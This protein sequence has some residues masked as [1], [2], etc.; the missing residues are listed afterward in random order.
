MVRLAVHP[1]NCN[2]KNEKNDTRCAAFALFEDTAL[3]TIV[4]QPSTMKQRSARSDSS[5]RSPMP[6]SRQRRRRRKR[7]AAQASCDPFV[8]LAAILV[9]SVL[10]F[11]G[12]VSFFLPSTSSS[13][14]PAKQPNTDTARD[15]NMGKITAAAAAGGSLRG[16]E[17]QNEAP[18][19]APVPAKRPPVKTFEG[20][21]TNPFEGWQPDPPPTTVS[22]A[23]RW[24]AC[25]DPKFGSG[26]D[27]TEFCREQPS[28]LEPI[29]D[30]S[31]YPGDGS[32]IP[33]VEIVRRMFLKGVDASGNAFP[34]PLDDE[35]C[36]PM[37]PR[38]QRKDI[39][40]E[41]VDAVN[42]S[43]AS[44]GAVVRPTRILCM[45]Y[46][47]A[48]AHP[49][50]IRAM[51]ETWMGRCDGFLA[52]S[53]ESDPR[54]P[55]I[56]LPHEGEEAY[57][58]M[59]QKVRSIWKFVGEHYVDRFDY[60]FLGGDDLFVVPENLRAYLSTLGSSDEDH[61]VGR[62]FKGYGKDNYFNSGGAGYALS[63]GLLKKYY[64]ALDDDRCGPHATTSMEDVKTAACLRKALQ[65]GLTDTRDERG[66]ERF[67]SPQ[68][69]IV[70]LLP[71]MQLY[72]FILSFFVH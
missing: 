65:V 52:F 45:V 59:W 72:L 34:P 6:L 70:L 38:G 42:V 39:N 22:P 61:F 10:L 68:A 50:R 9:A 27:C 11:F 23:C 62:R 2:S 1:Q 7:Q 64:S 37:G 20:G 18:K 4:G 55:A 58:N 33:D 29:P 54:I 28:S 56:S 67:V 13:S 3:G 46:T 17:I 35:L 16:A 66:R 44:D 71:Y 12:G 53:T 43:I 19:T 21:D 25:L 47:M 40:K 5:A 48:E 14:Q 8:V 26:A 41:M 57:N 30:Q 69:T 63:R 49:S 51:R 36:E 31:Q 15:N 60:F 24:R 32:W